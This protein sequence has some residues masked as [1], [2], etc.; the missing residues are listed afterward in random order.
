M[1]DENCERTW[2][3]Q[4]ADNFGWMVDKNVSKK[5]DEIILALRDMILQTS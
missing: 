3:N 2:Q 4:H 1:V 5:V